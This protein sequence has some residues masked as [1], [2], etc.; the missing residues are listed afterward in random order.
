MTLAQYVKNGNPMLSNYTEAWAC[1]IARI[2]RKTLLAMQLDDIF[3]IPMA[4][5]VAKREFDRWQNR[6]TL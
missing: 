2:N 1:R 5:E 3:K 4:G 6:G